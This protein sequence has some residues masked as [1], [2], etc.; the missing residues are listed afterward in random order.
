M[1]E[2][3]EEQAL[4]ISKL[5]EVGSGKL[6]AVGFPQNRRNKQS[7]DNTAT[8][9]G[10]LQCRTMLRTMPV[11]IPPPISF[12]FLFECAGWRDIQPINP[13]RSEKKACLDVE[14]P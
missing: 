13:F 12:L 6:T 5:V 7:V 8:M 11:K 3:L 4:T 2:E 14:L 1:K 10:G 9:L